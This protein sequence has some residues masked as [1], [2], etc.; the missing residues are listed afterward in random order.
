MKNIINKIPAPI[1]AAVKEALRLAVIAAVS[2]LIT[3]G[4]NYVANLP[5]TQTTLV[6]TFA[7]RGLD[8]WMHEYGKENDK[9][10]LSKGIVRF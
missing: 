5:E 1:I 9:V 6:L 10:Q 7:L 4:L 8:K 2:F 3:F